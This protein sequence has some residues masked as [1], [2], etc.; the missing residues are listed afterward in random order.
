MELAMQADIIVAGAA[1]KFGQPEINL[2][3]IPGAGGTQRLVRTVGKALAMRM[4]LT[5]EFIDADTAVS[6]GL[7]A[8]KTQPELAINRATEI[9]R[10]IARKSPIAVRLAKESVLNAFEN[11][12]QQGLD[13]ERKNFLFLAATEDRNEGL[14]AF[15]EKREPRF[16]GRG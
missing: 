11:H 9:A 3:I 2:G 7:A 10:T 15:L 14:Q 5:G 1:A 16:S 8:E 4:V 6:A 13:L 12:L